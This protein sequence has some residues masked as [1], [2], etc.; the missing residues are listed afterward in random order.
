MV[1]APQGRRG[2]LSRRE[3]LTSVGIIGAGLPILSVLGAC[4]QDD[5]YPRAGD[6]RFPRPDDPVTW[7]IYPENPPI[8]SDLP[9]EDVSTLEVYGWDGV[10]A[11]EVLRTFEQDHGVKVQ[12]S[13]FYDISEAISKLRAGAVRPDVFI[14]SLETIGRL[15]V[16][17]LIQPLNHDYLSYADNVW[18]QMLDP[19]YDLGSRYTMPYSVY[20]TGIGWR[21]DLVDLD[22][23]AMAN[24]WSVIGDEAAADHV[25]LLDDYRSAIGLI[26]LE[27]GT[28]DINTEDP[29]TIRAAS[30][31][32]LELS[33]RVDL[34]SSLDEYTLLPEGQAW[35]HQAWSGDMA[36]APYYGPQ[37]TD[38][39]AATLNYWFPED[40]IGEVSNDVMTIPRSAEH[41]VLA[42]TFIDYLLEPEHALENFSWVGYQQPLLS[43]TREAVIEVFPWLGQPSMEQALVTPEALADGLRQTELSPGADALWHQV[44][45]GFQSFG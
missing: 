14:P 25:F 39:T 37:D 17:E 36:A 4:T 19:F 27:M 11:P 15:V 3:F 6:L 12:L 35:I 13:T 38:A 24:P 43:L 10:I 41:P 9:P 28:G 26:L 1:P 34:K 33:H 32:L 45:L 31:R 22:P 23:D 40:G 44:W 5:P 21:S 7:S 16:A 8:A 20:S 2:R 18:P 42:H 29:A 30:E